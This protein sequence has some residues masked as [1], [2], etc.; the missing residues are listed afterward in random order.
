[1]EVSGLGAP[2]ALT[3]GKEPPVPV[4]QETRWAPEWVGTFWRREISLD[5]DDIRTPDLPG[6]S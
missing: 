1:M 4:E 3:P 2:V 6:R 5:S